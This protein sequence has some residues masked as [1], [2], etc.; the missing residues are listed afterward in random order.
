MVDQQVG[1]AVGHEELDHA[2]MG[3]TSYSSKLL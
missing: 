3:G 2:D 1:W